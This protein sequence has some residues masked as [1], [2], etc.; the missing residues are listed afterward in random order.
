MSPFNVTLRVGAFI[1]ALQKQKCC[2]HP[3]M[4]S[5]DTETRIVGGDFEDT[6]AVN[7]YFEK[8]EG[9]KSLVN[10]ILN[11]LG[12]QDEFPVKLLYVDKSATSTAITTSILDKNNIQYHHFREAE[13][14]LE[15]L[16]SD[17]ETTANSSFD[18]LNLFGAKIQAISNGCH[19]FSSS[20]F[21]AKFARNS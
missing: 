6:N 12:T 3:G 8:A 17:L 7:A 9:H 13:E 18:V 4:V 15:F 2:T 5:G 21:I 10:F 16:K 1:Q 14:G 19:S 11:F 20:F